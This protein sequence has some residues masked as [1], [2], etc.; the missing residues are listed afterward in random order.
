[1]TMSELPDDALPRGVTIQQMPLT[2]DLPFTRELIPS[3]KNFVS[4]TKFLPKVALHGLHDMQHVRILGLILQQYIKHD[5]IRLLGHLDG[6][7]CEMCAGTT[8]ERNERLH[9]M[10]EDH[11][12]RTTRL[13]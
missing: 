10:A 2:V 5:N 1:M 11:M 4:P 7:W 3:W 13:L 6:D 12:T 8:L 9:V